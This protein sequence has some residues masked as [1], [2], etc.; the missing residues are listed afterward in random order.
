HALSVSQLVSYLTHPFTLS[1]RRRFPAKH[2]LTAHEFRPIMRHFRARDPLI[3]RASRYPAFIFLSHTL[4]T[5]SS[6]FF[7][8]FFL[9]WIRIRFLLLELD[10]STP[11]ISKFDFSFLGLV[12]C[13][14]MQMIMSQKPEINNENSRFSGY[15]FP[16][17]ILIEVLRF[18]GKNAEIEIGACTCCWDVLCGYGL[19]MKGL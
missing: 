6:F 10:Q 11:F 14:C 1:S 13:R 16:V 8:F 19:F 7:F 9:I 18:D 17:D 3:L 2:V 12:F 4:F 15:G 5:T